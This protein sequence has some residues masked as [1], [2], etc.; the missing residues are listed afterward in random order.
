[1]HYVMSDIHGRKDKFE[2]LLKKINFCHGTDTLYVLGDVI[3]RGPQGIDL[4]ESFMMMES[5]KLFIGNHEQMMIFHYLFGM[6]D[7]LLKNNGGE[8]TKNAFEKR[9]K[10]EQK[11]ILDYLRENTYLVLKQNINGTLYQLSH[12]SCLP[13]KDNQLLTKDE[14]KTK[15]DWFRLMDLL[16][17]WGIHD[18]EQIK[19][20]KGD[21]I[22][23]VTGHKP[24]QLIE[25]WGKDQVYKKTFENNMTYIDIDC[26]CV[27]ETGKLACMC[28]ETGKITYE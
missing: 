10:E 3:D 13:I 28:L 17:G 19:I 4:I 25:G 20:L 12:A 11:R 14:V 1:M 23:F 18:K 26:G 9:T 21:P 16:W 2:K 7:W 5:I 15:Y 6:S 8:V 27:F 24:T 22:T